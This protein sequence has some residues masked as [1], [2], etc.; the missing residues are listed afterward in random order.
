[1][2]CSGFD[3]VMIHVLFSFDSCFVQNVSVW[4]AVFDINV[5][6]WQNYGY[7]CTS[8]SFDSVLKQQL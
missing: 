8:F 3:S 1:M 7:I 4:Q 5:S 6:I 2:F